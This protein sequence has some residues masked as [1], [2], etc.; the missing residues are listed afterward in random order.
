MKRLYFFLLLLAAFAGHMSAENAVL[1]SLRRLVAA[2]TDPAE[3]AVLYQELAFQSLYTQ[4]DSARYYARLSQQLAAGASQDSLLAEGWLIEG[5]G[6]FFQDEYDS[7]L[8]HYR[9]AQQI[10]GQAERYDRQAAILSNTASIYQLQGDY[11]QAL[12]SFQASLSLYENLADTPRHTIVLAN[13]A[14]L[15]AMSQNQERAIYYARRCLAMIDAYSE[16]EAPAM[17]GTRAQAYCNLGGA[18]LYQAQYDSALY[19]NRLGVQGIPYLGNPKL[20]LAALNNLAD[21]FEHREEW[22]SARHYFDRAHQQAQAFGYQEK[23]ALYAAFMADLLI[24]VEAYDQAEPYVA[25]AQ[26]W[27]D[28]AQELVTLEATYVALARYAEARGNYREA[29]GWS[30]SLESIRDELLDAE[31]VRALSDLQ[32][33]YETEKK[34]RLLAESEEALA[35]RQLWITGLVGLIV[36]LSLTGVVIGLR[37]Q[38]QR[39]K[40]LL[41][42]KEKGLQAVIEATESERRR[43]ARDL[44]DGIG[45]ELGSLMLAFEQLQAA[46]TQGVDRLKHRLQSSIGQ[47]RSLSHQMMPRALELAG[48]APA[49]EELVQQTFEDAA[50]EAEFDAFRLPEE[51]DPQVSL[52]AYRVAQELISNVI[53]HAEATEVSVQ[54]SAPRDILALTVEDNGRGFTPDPQAPGIGL[55]NMRTR[56]QQVG[57]TLTYEPGEDGGTRALVRIPLG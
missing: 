8:V 31:R 17:L 34:E 9:R 19:Y 29:L 30:D 13:M 3:Q 21:V 49:L 44:H 45:Q 51:L 7:A 41:A 43:I 6:Y 18:Y 32:V 20:I 39:R 4:P 10:H 50:I 55:T 2:T 25:E 5:Y 11:P 42:A 40:A 48:L 52:V 35:R 16:A 14:S 46:G 15:H 23:A 38:V 12:A 54:L 56:L 33:K 28:S 47:V 57:G 36:G 27:I 24:D 37:S 26:A 1:D 22:D 53:R